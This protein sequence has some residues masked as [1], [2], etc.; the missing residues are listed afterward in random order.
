MP[1]PYPCGPVICECL[2]KKT[3][4]EKNKNKNTITLFLVIY[5]LWFLEFVMLKPT[6]NNLMNPESILILEFFVIS[7][8]I[9]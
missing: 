8:C 9:F 1:S 3:Q 5:D 6:L 2:W 4:I 7:S